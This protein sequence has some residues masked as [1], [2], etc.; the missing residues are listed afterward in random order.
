MRENAFT[1]VTKGL[2]GP[3]DRGVN[4]RDGGKRYKGQAEF[5]S[6]EPSGGEARV[7]NLSQD[8]RGLEFM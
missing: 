1:E 2:S 8:L 6:G 4:P 3:Q 7:K 5:T